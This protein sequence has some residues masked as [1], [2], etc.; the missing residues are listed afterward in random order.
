MCGLYAARRMHRLRGAGASGCACCSAT[1]K[2][3][4][5][6]SYYRFILMC[7]GLYVKFLCSQMLKAA[8]AEIN[9][10]STLIA[11]AMAGA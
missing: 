9:A 5:G 7:K 1:L 10:G 4:R 6:L 11:I 3:C 8:R 2:T